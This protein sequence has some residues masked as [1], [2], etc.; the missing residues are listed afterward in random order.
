MKPYYETELGKLYHGDCLKIMPQLESVDLVLTDPPYNC[1][2]DYG[3]CKDNYPEE[4]YIGF[5]FDVANLSRSLAKNQAWIA[6][7]YKLRFFLGLFPDS[8][9]V[10]ITRGA[11]GPYRGGWSDQFQI[12]LSVGKPSV[13]FDDLWSDI[14]LKG[15]GYFFRENDFGH[16]GY[17][18]QLIMTRFVELLSVESVIDPFMGTG[19]TAIACE[20]LDRK[21]I[22]IEIEEKYCEISA[23]R[24]ENERRQLKL[25]R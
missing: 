12:A 20:R 22:G 13:C 7:R 3:T 9:L 11:K 17:T 25:F 23:K 6:P 2:K 19:T 16:P 10:V 18:P 4:E 1:G 21:W 8:H 15:A 24:I 5:I 14:R